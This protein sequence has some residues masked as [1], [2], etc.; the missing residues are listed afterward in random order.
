MLNSSIKKWCAIAALLSCS[1]SI[2]QV[3][4]TI[5]QIYDAARSGKVA[6]A[7]SMMQQVLTAHPNSARLI[8]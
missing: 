4:P 7:E 3:E 5:N 1:L 8:F 6:Q 2:A